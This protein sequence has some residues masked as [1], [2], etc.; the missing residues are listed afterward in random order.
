VWIHH[1]QYD[2]VINHFAPLSLHADSTEMQWKKSVFCPFYESWVLRH[3]LG[4]TPFTPTN[5]GDLS[6][7]MVTQVYQTFSA[8]TFS[9]EI[10]KVNK[11]MVI[12]FIERLFS[13]SYPTQE[14]FT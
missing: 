3:I 13:V 1:P 8:V 5:I 4:S 11:K 9:T 14:F 12:R 6:H 2:L 10:K 7:D